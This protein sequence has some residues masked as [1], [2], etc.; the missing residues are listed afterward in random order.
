MLTYQKGI[1][2]I[3]MAWIL[4]K[5]HTSTLQAETEAKT[6]KLTQFLHYLIQNLNFSKKKENYNFRRKTLKK[7]QKNK[8]KIFNA[9]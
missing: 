6:I 2:K 9:F 7:H 3:K 8:M 1:F 5:L 4:S